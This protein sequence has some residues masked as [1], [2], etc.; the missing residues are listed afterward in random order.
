MFARASMKLGL[1]RAVLQSM[2]VVASDSGA[3]TKKDALSAKEVESLLKHGA[4]AAFDTDDTRAAQFET[5]DIDQILQRSTTI[6]HGGDCAGGGDQTN[7]FSKAAFVENKD[8]G[9]PDV[10]D[11]DFWK[12][13]MGT[14]TADTDAN[15]FSYKRAR[16]T[17]LPLQQGKSRARADSNSDD[18]GDE[19]SDSDSDASGGGVDDEDDSQGDAKKQ[20]KQ[21]LPKLDDSVPAS[22]PWSAAQR[23]AVLNVLAVRGYGQWQLSLQAVAECASASDA[24]APPTHNV[25]SVRALVVCFIA[26]VVTALDSTMVLRL[27]LAAIR[28]VRECLCRISILPRRMSIVFMSLHEET[29]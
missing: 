20:Q 6:V 7:A 12:K 13:M 10:D 26:E 16:K 21:P 29:H 4:Y 15:E 17:V 14:T 5:D 28:Q 19:H 8:K 25:A 27:L 22:S 2:A 24:P 3:S 23:D 11:P 18:S 9:G 1:D